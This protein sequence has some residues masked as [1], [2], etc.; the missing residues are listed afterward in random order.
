[1]SGRA[2]VARGHLAEKEHGGCQGSQDDQDEDGAQEELPGSPPLRQGD[3]TGALV[4]PGWM[5]G[6][7]DHRRRAPS[8][9]ISRR[10]EDRVGAL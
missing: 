6:F 2:T 10:D 5:S 4:I 3:L 7:E 9:V 1:M 8:L